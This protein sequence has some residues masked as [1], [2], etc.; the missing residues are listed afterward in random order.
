MK[1]KK[2]TL[3]NFR[4]FEHLEITFPVKTWTG[5]QL[6]YEG[7]INSGL[8][9]LVAANGQG[10]TAVIEAAMYL[11][12]SIVGHFPK[13]S[14]PKVRETDFHIEYQHSKN[15]FGKSILKKKPKAAYMRIAAETDEKMK[16][17]IT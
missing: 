12:G 9:V 16:W 15:S 1:L 3:D 13:T 5:E 2:L 6:S 14:V 11:L 8:T 17:D 7:D 10:K 4:C